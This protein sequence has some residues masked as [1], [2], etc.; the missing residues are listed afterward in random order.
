MRSEES[1]PLIGITA[2]IEHKN[3]KTYLYIDLR[4]GKLVEE[5]GGIPILIHP[6]QSAREVVSKINGL[7]LS[8]GEDIHP[9]YYREEPRYQMTPSPDLRTEFEFSLLREAMISKIPI[10]GI[11]HGMQLIN[12]ALGGTLYQDLPGQTE[13]VINHRL[14]EKRHRVSIEGDSLLFQGIG[15]NEIEVT[16]THH[17]AVKDLGTGLKVSATAHDGIIE[18]FEMPGYPFLIGVQWHPEKGPDEN[19]RKLLSAFLKITS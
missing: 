19:S 8:G 9:K 4:Y 1:K 15:E 18:A 2:D 12:V 7:I 6:T 5:A 11:C 17:Q 3:G 16:S 14:G 13:G 10:L